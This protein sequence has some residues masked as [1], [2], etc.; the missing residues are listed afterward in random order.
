MENTF[1]RCIKKGKK[2]V[3]I[4]VVDVGEHFVITHVG[5]FAASKKKLKQFK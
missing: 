2:I 4:V 1:E 5:I 3:K